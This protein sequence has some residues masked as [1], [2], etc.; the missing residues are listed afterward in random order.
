MNNTFLLLWLNLLELFST[1]LIITEF[2]LKTIIVKKKIHEF[3]VLI[4]QLLFVCLQKKIDRIGNNNLK[5]SDYF[6]HL[7]VVF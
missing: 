5:E 7:M 1:L 4:N 3:S 6:E 2:E